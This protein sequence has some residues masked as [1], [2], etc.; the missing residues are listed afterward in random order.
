V[1]TP[2]EIGSRWRE[3]LGIVLAVGL[4]PCSGALI[5]LAFALS[6]GLL[7]AGITA[8]LLMGLGTAATTGVLA[9]LA[10]S[11]K[12]LALRLAGTDSPVTRRVVWWAEMLA[13]LAVLAFGL[14][15]LLSSL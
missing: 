6:Q 12:G 1:V 11:A 14:L 2:A 4:R 5:V 9:A 3:Q 8:V 10:V 7:A 15:L 13:A